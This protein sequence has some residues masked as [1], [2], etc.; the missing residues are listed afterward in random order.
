MQNVQRFGGLLVGWA[1]GALVGLL[2]AAQA[3]SHV[4]VPDPSVHLWGVLLDG[5]VGA[6]LGLLAGLLLP[7]L[8][9]VVA[10]I[11]AVVG[12]VATAFGAWVA[13]APP[14]AWVVPPPIVP[15]P[16]AALWVMVPG[17][18]G[19]AEVDPAWPVLSSLAGDA[20][21]FP[22]V[23]ASSADPVDAL[24]T[25]VSGRRPAG[26]EQARFTVGD[27]IAW[28]G[29]TGVAVLPTDDV[30]LAPALRGMA[31]VVPVVGADGHGRARD[32]LALHR[33]LV[34]PSEVAGP[35]PD[36]VVQAAREAVA[37]VTGPVGLVVVLPPGP[38]SALD[39]ALADLV[40]LVPPDAVVLVSG[41]PGPRAGD[42]PPLAPAA[43]VQPAWLTVGQDD[44][45]GRRVHG[46]V[47]AVELA[48]RWI[49]QIHKLDPSPFEG[50]LGSPAVLG[51]AL[52]VHEAP[53]VLAARDES[54]GLE[55]P[56]SC[57]MNHEVSDPHRAAVTVAGDDLAVRWAGY[58]WVR[59]S[60][61]DALYDERIDPWWTHD[62]LAA[63]GSLCG[64]RAPAAWVD[65]LKARV[66]DLDAWSVA[67][68]AVE[69]PLPMHGLPDADLFPAAP[70]AED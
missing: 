10:A 55:G 70:P 56:S 52:R 16:R 65:D 43:A 51:R 54:G 3:A 19:D 33:W 6:L 64:D 62:L 22:H 48:P 38:P 32:H 42:V 2:D 7:A 66:A 58:T 17:L 50:V 41:L 63:G 69:P 60:G 15:V 11:A 45:A 37:A 47:S 9:A 31:G 44:L 39:A 29:L 34:R 59:R 28:T 46:A 14:P 21:A 27:A 30:A 4:L 1:I 53:E 20:L 35:A 13:Q 24:A 67:Q 68:A 8:P 5:V 18:P 40:A 61:Q 12:V 25:A 36:A 57:T 23:V 26:R 49:D